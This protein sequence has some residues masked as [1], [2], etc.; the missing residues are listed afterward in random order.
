M[1]IKKS[2]RLPPVEAAVRARIE[3]AKETI[4]VEHETETPAGWCSSRSWPPA[5]FETQCR[6]DTT[7]SRAS[8][9]CIT[10]NSHHDWNRTA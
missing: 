2:R 4:R 5:P 3:A 6:F 1:P 9:F 8:G 10:H 7:G